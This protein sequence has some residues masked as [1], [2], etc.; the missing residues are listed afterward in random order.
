MQGGGLRGVAVAVEGLLRGPLHEDQ[1]VAQLDLA[2]GRL[3]ELAERDDVAA[4]RLDL[5]RR[6]ARVREVFI[7]VCDVEQVERVY[8]TGHD[9]LLRRN[10]A[11]KSAKPSTP[12]PA[13][14]QSG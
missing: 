10:A 5:L 13:R 1:D 9:C 2:G 11:Q 14:I 12:P 3:A 8:G 4:V 7:A 6:P